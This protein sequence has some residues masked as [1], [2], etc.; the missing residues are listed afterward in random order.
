MNL[1]PLDGAAGCGPGCGRCWL[2]EFS[3]PLVVLTVTVGLPVMGWVG[4]I[5]NTYGHFSLTVMSG[6]HLV[7]HTG[8]FFEYVPDEDAALRDTYI[9][10]RDAHIAEYGTQTNTIWK[11]IPE[12][13]QVTGLNFYDLSREL[14]RISVQLILAHPDLYARNLVSG[15]GLFWL[16]P[17]YWS[18]EML[19][20][21]GLQPVLRVLILFERG[22]LVL[23]NLIFIGTSLAAL[24]VK[25]VRQSWQISAEL[26]ALAGTV[27]LG[28]IVQTMLDHGDNPRFLIPLQSVVVLWVVWVG[29]RACSHALR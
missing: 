16:A 23:A 14:A 19:R 24:L 21:P 10:Y 17:V 2:L 5:Y 22:L 11:A 15:W 28:S 8:V 13:S 29:W 20:W 9:R 27:W 26:W 7:Q 6:Y 3:L 12:L 4:Y 18:P 1:H 25:C